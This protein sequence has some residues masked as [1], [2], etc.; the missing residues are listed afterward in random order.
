M[1]RSTRG[2]AVAA[3]VAGLAL[4]GCAAEDSGTTED[5]A[6]GGATTSQVAGTTTSSSPVP[7]PDGEPLELPGPAVERWTALDGPDGELGPPVGPATEVADGSLTEFER[8]VIVV[9]PTARAFVVQGRIL[10]AY[11]EAG[12]PSGELGFPTSDETTTDGGWITTFEHGTIAFLD[13]DAVVEV[14]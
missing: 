8:G 3:V 13:G 1:Y 9:D 10:D 12:G 14:R 4:A 7:G 2:I 11:R 5:A 6:T